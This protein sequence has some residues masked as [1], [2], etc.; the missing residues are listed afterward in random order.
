MI[1]CLTRSKFCEWIESFKPEITLSDDER[2]DSPSTST[3]EDTVQVILGIMMEGYSD[4]RDRLYV[5]QENDGIRAFIKSL[6]DM[7]N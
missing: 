6:R 2:L 7:I 3:F 1:A 4:G 5:S